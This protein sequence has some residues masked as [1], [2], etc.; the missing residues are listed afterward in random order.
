M[1]YGS[2]LEPE[3][4]TLP[5]LFPTNR[6]M[7]GVES[8]LI[9]EIVG[10][11][12]HVALTRWASAIALTIFVW[13]NLLTLGDEVYF[14]WPKKWSSVKVC[15]YG[16]RILCFVALVL[17]TLQLDTTHRNFTYEF[18]AAYFHIAGYFA[19]ASFALCN[20][21]LLVRAHALLGGKRN[22]F[23]WLCSLFAVAYAGTA[24]LVV[25]ATLGLQSQLYYS[26]V[27]KACG[28]RELPYLMPFLWIPAGIF[29]TIVFTI[30]VTK[31]YRSFQL[32][33]CLGS[34]LFMVLYRDGVAYYLVSRNP[35][36]YE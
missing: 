17:N 8:E 30:T 6:A 28:I 34:D 27:F 22:H 29:E 7:D 11:G 33:R 13:D 3:N 21:I 10:V 20:W 18:C 35:L 36:E 32:S 12:E 14:I 19:Y 1:R 5:L 9:R 16:N 2:P 24:V 15:T 25:I 23:V 31:V 26:D 4:S